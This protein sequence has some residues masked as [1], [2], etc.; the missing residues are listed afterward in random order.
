MHGLGQ[1]VAVRQGEA[2]GQWRGAQRVRVCQCERSY[3]ISHQSQVS[4]SIRIDDWLVEENTSVFEKGLLRQSRQGQRTT[5]NWEVDK[6]KTRPH[7]QRSEQG[8][9]EDH[10]TVSRP[11]ST[12]Q[13]R[14][15]RRV[16]RPIGLRRDPPTRHP[17]D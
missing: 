11:T 15:K 17:L 9:G 16:A 1:G 7:E 3:G 2:M 10:A 14:A 4:T 12:L 5:E 8:E 6:K 13:R